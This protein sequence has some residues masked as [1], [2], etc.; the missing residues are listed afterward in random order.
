MNF[1]DYTR[2]S[3]IEV[4]EARY[5]DTKPRNYRTLTSGW[6]HHVKQTTLSVV[7]INRKHSIARY[8]VYYQN[9]YRSVKMTDSYRKMEYDSATGMIRRGKYLLRVTP[10]QYNKITKHRIPKGFNPYCIYG[11]TIFYQ[12]EAMHVNYKAYHL[13]TGKIID[14]IAYGPLAHLYL[15]ISSRGSYL[16]VEC[17]LTDDDIVRFENHDVDSVVVDGND[18]YFGK[19][20]QFGRCFKLNRVSDF[21]YYY[22]NIVNPPNVDVDST[23]VDAADYTDSIDDE[24]DSIDATDFT[25]SDVDDTI[26]DTDSTNDESDSTISDTDSTDDESESII[27]EVGKFN[28]KSNIRDTNGKQITCCVC[29]ED[30]AS[31]AIVPCGHSD[32]CNLCIA[33]LTKLSACAICRTKV[34]KFIKLF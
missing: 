8:A 1:D 28:I 14:F 3:L 21:E 15:S 2:T 4:D 23:D 22:L 30:A 27:I 32:Y 18:L 20:K 6:K 31:Y 9:G 7:R 25:T 16:V 33:K 34:D 19:P 17:A 29:F 5:I 12:N 11:N 24:S 26:S 13:L 10:Q